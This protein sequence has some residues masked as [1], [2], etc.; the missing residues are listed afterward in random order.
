MQVAQKGAAE[1]DRGQAFIEEI[2]PLRRY[3][4]DEQGRAA[5]SAHATTQ[6]WHGHAF[7][8]QPVDLA[9]KP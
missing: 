1:N 3:V 6:C 5:M 4:L 8:I 9:R 7:R 2:S